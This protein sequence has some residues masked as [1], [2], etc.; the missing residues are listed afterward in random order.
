MSTVQT[1]RLRVRP[2]PLKRSRRTWRKP[3]IGVHVVI[4]L[5]ILIS[6]LPVY[7]MLTISVKNPLQY[8]HERWNVSFPMRLNNYS[9]AWEVIHSYMWN[10]IFVGVVGFLGM[11]VLSV[12]GGY[13]FA[14]LRFPFREQLYFAMIALLSVPWVISFIPSYVLYNTL[15]LVNTRWAL[16]VPNIASGPIFGTFLLRSF[17][18]GIPEEI[19]ESARLDGAGH[20][21][22][23]TR[24][25][26][27]L[28][29]PII[30]TLAVLN[31]VS[32]WNSFL[33]P[34]V[35]VSDKEMQMISVGLFLLSK[36]VSVSGDFAVWGPLF[37]GYTIASL[38]LAILFFLLGKFYVEG[39][40]ESGLKA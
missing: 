25:T 4:I 18:A 33:W 14:R 31:F 15:G 28:S 7:E 34:M 1:K 17:F 3:Q 10:T 23:I 16:I 24:I 39:L 35:S 40:I 21:T 26:M 30:A 6:L 11:L 32:T 22:L 9:A 36:E 19:Y 12:I 20:G 27:P 2:K 37:A 29:L 13:V 38:P 5:L 8:Q